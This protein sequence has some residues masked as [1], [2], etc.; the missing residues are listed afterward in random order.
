VS[1]IE[2]ISR[3]TGKNAKEERRTYG[4]EDENGN[5]KVSYIEYSIDGKKVKSF[6]VEIENSLILPIEEGGIL[7][8]YLKEDFE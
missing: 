8:L 6:G 2:N 1:C 7:R 4:A 5:K 3:Y